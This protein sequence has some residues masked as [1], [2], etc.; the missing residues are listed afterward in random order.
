MAGG[1]AETLQVTVMLLPKAAPISLAF[2]FDFSQ[3]GRSEE[4]L[5]GELPHLVKLCDP[6]DL[7]FVNNFLCTLRRR[8]VFQ[9]FTQTF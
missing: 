7:K 9:Y 1:L 3:K 2:F 5:D 6:H 8:I 4:R